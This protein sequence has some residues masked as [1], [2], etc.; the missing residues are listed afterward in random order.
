MHVEAQG[1]KFSIVL[2]NFSPTF[3]L[4]LVGSYIL[5]SLGNRILG[6]QGVVWGTYLIISFVR[7][8]L[9][10]LKFFLVCLAIKNYFV[11]L[12][13]FCLEGKTK[14]KS[15]PLWAGE[16]TA[17]AG[18]TLCL[19]CVWTGTVLS[20]AVVQALGLPSCETLGHT[21]SEH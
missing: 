8:S 12:I 4:I 13:L 7:N 21:H 1:R 5:K 11:G 20:S 16:D 2:N 18:R 15:W 14:F 17:C 10:L 9:R 6:K 19:A 3:S